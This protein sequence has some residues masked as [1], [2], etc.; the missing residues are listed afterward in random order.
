MLGEDNELPTEDE[1]YAI[2][3][4]ILER[5]KDKPVVIR[6]F[7]LGGDKGAIVQRSPHGRKPRSGAKSHP[8]A[9]ARIAYPEKAN[10]STS[11]CSIFGKLKFLIP[12]VTSLEELQ[13]T[14]KIVKELKKELEIEG[15]PS[16]DFV[17]IGCMIEVPSAALF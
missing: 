5:L 14:N 1:Q 17:G 9:F 8:A 2:Y 7:D 6:A 4:E 11:P 10:T 3:K 15:L 12:M 16:G 13:E